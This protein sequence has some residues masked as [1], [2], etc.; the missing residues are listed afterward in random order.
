MKQDNVFKYY[1]MNILGYAHVQWFYLYEKEEIFS[2][3]CKMA[4]TVLTDE[5]CKNWDK[6]GRSEL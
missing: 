4:G 6:A 3:L 2:V 1:L 5:L